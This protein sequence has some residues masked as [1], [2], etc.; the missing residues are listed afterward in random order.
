MMDAAAAAYVALTLEGTDTLL[1]TADHALRRELSRRIRD[2]LITLGIVTSGPTV[3]IADG[4]RASPGDLIIATHNDHGVEAGEPGRTLANGDLL[5][6]ET[7]AP[8]GLV[9]RRALDAD[10]ATG[11]R[12]WTSST[13]LY[14]AYTDAELGYAVTDHVAQGRTVRTGLAVLT[15]TEDRQHALVAMTRGT[16]ANLAYVFTQSPKRTDPVPGPRPAPELTR[17]DRL[18]SERTGDNTLATSPAPPGTP[19][20]ILSQ[21]RPA[22]NGPDRSGGAAPRSRAGAPAVRRT[23]TPHVGPAPSPRRTGSVQ[24]SR[25]LRRSLRDDPSPEDSASQAGSSNRAP[26]GAEADPGIWADLRYA[27]GQPVDSRDAAVAPPISPVS[28]P[29]QREAGPC[30]EDQVR[31]VWL[32]GTWYWF[33]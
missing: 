9:V 23:W 32:G 15:G 8:A 29:A 13:F 18:H 6:I 1:M 7:V 2:D 31:S 24:G 12:Q 11:R 22:G 25:R 14:A 4:T 20:G 5:R 21:V 3:T 27:N 19:L 10:P 16:D 30:W 33:R 28:C 17:H 26:Q